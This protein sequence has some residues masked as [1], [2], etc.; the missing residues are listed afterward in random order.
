MATLN[1]GMSSS[2]GSDNFVMVENED[3]NGVTPESVTAPPHVGTSI[4]THVPREREDTN[5]TLERQ[6]DLTSGPS[7]QAIDT[8]YSNDLEFF[9]S[10][11]ST[12]RLEEGFSGSMDAKGHEKFKAN[13]K[14]GTTSR[15]LDRQGFGWLLEVEED[16]N[17]PQKPLL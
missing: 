8:Q 16:E 11:T 13:Q 17:E 14:S 4:L 9:N 2:G 3:F 12:E 5:I 15:L 7:T 10:S 6:T 1:E